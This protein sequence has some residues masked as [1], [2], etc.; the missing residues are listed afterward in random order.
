[1][2][3]LSTQGVQAS[4]T[5]STGTLRKKKVPAEG[6]PSTGLQADRQ[7]ASDMKGDSNKSTRLETPFEWVTKSPF[8][9]MNLLF[10]FLSAALA[11]G[12]AILLVQRYIAPPNRY[13]EFN[14][15]AASW[16][17]ASK[18]QDLV[19]FPAFI[20]GFILTGWAMYRFF[21]VVSVKGGRDYESSLT[22]NLTWWLLPFAAG[23]GGM[24]SPFPKDL[25]F[26]LPFGMVGLCS[27]M[28]L[29][30]ANLPHRAVELGGLTNGVIAALFFA[31][32][33]AALCGLLERMFTKVALPG[34][35]GGITAML[36]LHAMAISAMALT[37]RFRP[38]T[39]RGLL[40]KALLISQTGIVLFYTLL[41]P[42]IFASESEI[43]IVPFRETLPLLSAALAT[44]GWLDLR[45]RWLAFK[46][47]DHKDSNNLFSPWAVFALSLLL[48]S[49]QGFEPMIPTDDLRFGESLMGWWS[50]REFGMLPYIDLLT[51]QGLVGD[52]FTGFVSW[53]FLDGTAGTLME[54]NRLALTIVSLAAF[55]GLYRFTG[56]LLISLLCVL[57][58]AAND[59]REATLGFFAL[60]PFIGFLMKHPPMG[61]SNRWLKTWP[62]TAAALV[63][64]MP[65]PGIALLLSTLPILIY[66]ASRIKK[67]TIETYRWVG[68]GLLLAALALSPLPA[69]LKGAVR[70]T[71]EEWSVFQ[72]AYGIPW[73][74][75]YA[76][77]SDPDGSLL[78]RLLLDFFRMG[79]TWVLLGSVVVI[80]RLSRRRDQLT[81][82]VTVATP[83]AVLLLLL[84]T[85]AM[86][87]IEP[88][89]PSAAG[90]LT[91]FSFTV[92]LPVLM[93]PWLKGQRA[94]LPA[95]AI[96]FMTAGLGNHSLG[97]DGLKGTLEHVTKAEPVDAASLGLF[98]I[99]KASMAPSHV[100]RLMRVNRILKRNLRHR[101]TYLDLTGN[102]AHHLYFD[103]PP[104]MST[105]SPYNLVTAARQDREV[106][107][108]MRK[109]PALVLLEADNKTTS[110]GKA[111]LRS[112]LLYRFVAEGYH[113]ELHDGYV[114]GFSDSLLRSEGNMSFTLSGQ[115]DSV[116]HKGVHRSASALMVRD[117]LTVGFLKPGDR[118]V[119][120]NGSR[121]P[122][123][124]AS[125]PDRTVWLE[126]PLP[127]R[128]K[129]DDKTLIPVVLDSLRAK[130]LSGTLMRRVFAHDDLGLVPVTWGRSHYSLSKRMTEVLT[131][132]V[133][134]S[135]L[136]GFGRVGD[137]L[138]L[139]GDSPFMDFSLDS[140]SLGGREA[141]LLSMVFDCESETLHACLIEVGWWAKGETAPGPDRKLVFEAKEGRLIVPLDSH[142]DWLATEG[143][144]GL[145]IEMKDGAGCSRIRF[146]DFSLHQRKAVFELSRDRL[147]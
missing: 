121:L 96:V 80:I 135:A 73:T 105:P 116:W 7:S 1:M 56:H 50:L 25:L 94:I 107:R 46:G 23:I 97:I 76:E 109:P 48:K 55:F 54:A 126:G 114:F 83:V 91:S 4:A 18:Y 118:I 117:S 10:V 140:V 79:W 65:S 14:V 47:S 5:L 22:R 136:H 49:G 11:G 44:M 17:A 9:R 39:Y 147:P 113:A 30:W 28:L 106:R 66:H 75:G 146:A 110:E 68:L 16:N 145:R 93:A 29:T 124:K 92:L 35:E 131:L 134:K 64:L 62:L 84:S 32:L 31:M 87:R 133:K 70:H 108:L 27:L 119:L 141:G 100:D 41:V 45:R 12:A 6:V 52:Y 69:M 132:D 21:A 20:A 104:A 60:V 85:H 99:G 139:T 3:K 67:E 74:K 77:L 122:I 71:W 51:R 59:H 130:E 26:L 128:N 90:T 123:K 19:S 115:T 34:F 38:E 42:D 53:L 40:P 37:V 137:R 125:V 36:V 63:L 8:N 143:I 61:D 120:P 81:Y 82:V 112:H 72:V 86:G 57:F 102:L 95:L 43:S 88:F 33:P 98:N 58:F 24:L 101:E 13:S 103:R 2:R 127:E 144:G 111:S 78:R 142:P 138:V 129:P 15:G 89:S